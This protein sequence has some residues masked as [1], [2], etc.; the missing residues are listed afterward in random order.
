MNKPLLEVKELAVRF[1]L[2]ER[3]VFAVNGVDFTVEEGQVV[4][5]VGESGCGKS[6]TSLS[7]MRLIQKPGRIESG[8]VLLRGRDKTL[9]LL[10]LS[11]HDMEH[12]RGN[13][14]SMIF[15]DPM[16]SLNPVLTIGYQLMEPLKLHRGLSTEEAREEA[17]Q[18]LDR[19]G[20]P[21]P[22]GRLKEYPHQYSGGMR[23]RVMI[24]MAVAC[25]PDLLIADEPSTSLDVTI[26]AQI[27][28][29]LLA[30]KHDLGTAVIIITHDLGVI[31]E[32]AEKVVVMYAGTVVESGP[33]KEIFNMPKHPYTEALMLS[34]PPLHD[35]PE[36]LA[37]IKGTPPMVLSPLTQCPFAPRC[38]KIIP[39]CTEKRPPLQ[40]LTPEHAV[41]C[42]VTQAR[43]GG[44]ND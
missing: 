36:R 39:R 2:S 6:V 19:V 16:T 40:H 30:L 3:T 10:Q 8:Q 41:A 5:L 4:G 9:D 44:Y 12:V 23:Q 29:L 18:L 20:I 1:H 35:A 26:Q 7:I 27:L 21:E 38:P 14:I 11:K 32:L 31:A 43:E 17:I 33:V 15:Q 13:R 28:D 24:A 25:S 42:W 22:R 34:I 37:T